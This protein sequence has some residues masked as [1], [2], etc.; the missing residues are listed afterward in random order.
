[1]QPPNIAIG[2]QSVRGLVGFGAPSLR[3]H[4]GTRYAEGL[5]REGACVA[6]TSA[7]LGKIADTESHPPL[8]LEAE[9]RE[10][11]IVWMDTYAQRLGSFDAEQ[12][13]QLAE[14][15]RQSADLL[16]ER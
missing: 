7:I 5:S 4:V 9:D 2:C 8:D 1:M 12:E 11:L 6:A 14:L 10:R 3:T 15:R 16:H 13:Q